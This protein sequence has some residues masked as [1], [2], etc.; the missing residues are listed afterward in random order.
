M[1]ETEKLTTQQLGRYRLVTTLGQGGMGTI[2]LAVAGGLGEFRKL[3]VIKELRW[4]LTRNQRFVEMFL[5]EAKLA[6]RL[7][8]PNVVQTLEAG[9][10]AGRYFLSMEFLD[11]QPLSE[12]MLRATQDASFSLGVRLRILCGA[13]TGLHYAHELREYDGTELQ[14]VHR[15][16]SPHN[17]FVTYDGQVKVVD[18]GIAKAADAENSTQPG[19]FKGKFAYASPEQIKGQPVDRRADVFAMGVLLWEL[20]TLQRFA[21][22]KLTQ[23]AFD[24]RLTGME[25]RLSQVDADV[26]PL[27]AEICDRAM[28]V[29][30]DKRFAS[31]EELRVA[32]EQYLFVS[33]ERVDASAIGGI[34]QTAFAAERA[35]MHRMI[36]G[37]LKEANYGESLVR[38][39][40]PV[41][42]PDDP[43]TV[44][45][46]SLLVESSRGEPTPSV[47]TTWDPA[48][49]G[50]NRKLWLAACAVI[51]L[52]A[53]AAYALP[54]LRPSATAPASATNSATTAPTTIPSATSSTVPSFAPTPAP[55]AAPASTPEPAAAN[56]RVSIEAA[57]APA[58][59]PATQPSPAIAAPSGDVVEPPARK[60]SRAPGFLPGS[61]FSVDLD[62]PVPFSQP[63][64]ADES[65]ADPEAREQPAA[66]KQPVSKPRDGQAPSGG[67]EIGGDMRS[68]RRDQRRALDLEDPFK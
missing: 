3:L 62:G 5:D 68:L 46:L 25:P 18:F 14:I 64:M 19:I 60:A 52:V 6:A 9:E 12:V 56:V 43:T 63:T 20:V 23:Q 29:D 13:L 37:H 28:H 49:R 34:M 17:V 51:T 30:P 39:L 2:W 55:S 24:A 7:N 45:D 32:I 65:T 59:A 38:Q 67:V 21:K 22:G 42:S 44:A 4:D 27:L 41:I 50:K 58:P 31:A 16:I 33:G 26:E 66:S 1:D 53:I 35:S 10:E 54:G 47:Q 11:G 61:M 8:H 15:D 48:L 36:D 40:R 57:S